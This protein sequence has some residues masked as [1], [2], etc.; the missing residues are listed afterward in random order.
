[1]T[2]FIHED[3]NF[4]LLW[5]T[6]TESSDLSILTIHLLLFYLLYLQHLSFFLSVSSHLSKP[7][8]PPPSLFSFLFS[9]PFLIT[10]RAWHSKLVKSTNFNSIKL[11]KVAMTNRAILLTHW[12]QDMHYKQTAVSCQIKIIKVVAILRKTREGKVVSEGS[13]RRV[14]GPKAT[15]P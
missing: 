3:T 12:S 9:K 4:A 11:I 15:S 7:T 6:I 14:Q 13:E 1:M 2:L 5:T 10:V 8:P